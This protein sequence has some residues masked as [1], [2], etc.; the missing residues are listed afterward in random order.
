MKPLGRTFRE[1]ISAENGQDMVEY[2]LVMALVSLIAIGAITL[3]GQTIK[4]FW[5]AVPGNLP[6]L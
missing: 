3:A 5:D 1:A 6:N 4:G 2:V